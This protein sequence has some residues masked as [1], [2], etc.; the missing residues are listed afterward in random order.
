MYIIPLINNG[1]GPA[2]IKSFAIK[3]DG[4]LVSGE[5]TDAID[6]ALK[7]MFPNEKIYAEYS[8][9]GKNYAMSP[10]DSCKVV[11]VE[12]L[13]DNPPSSECVEQA[14]NRTDLEVEYES[15][16]S[17]KF[18]FSTVDGRPQKELSSVWKYESNYQVMDSLSI[19]LA[20]KHLA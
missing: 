7:I 17:E 2:L 6:K 3:V 11:T 16:H 20:P 4:R 13:A 9:L 5:G 10:K 19:S 15:F 8:S 18:S 12:F 1:L 14:M